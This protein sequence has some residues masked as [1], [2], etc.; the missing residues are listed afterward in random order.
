MNGDE[1]IRQNRQELIALLDTILAK[2]VDQ[3]HEN[4]LDCSGKICATPRVAPP[5]N[6]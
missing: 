4:P 5:Q 2:A 3:A 6:L 1:P